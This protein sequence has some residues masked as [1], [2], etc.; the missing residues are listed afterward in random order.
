MNLAKAFRNDVVSSLERVYYVH[1]LV[2]HSPILKKNA[3]SVFP[4]ED[5]FLKGPVSYP[6]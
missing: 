3:N 4:V 6:Q 2:T 1:L 5:G